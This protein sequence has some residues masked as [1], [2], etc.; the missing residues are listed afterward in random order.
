MRLI[1]GLRW[2]MGAGNEE[3]LN[4]AGFLKGIGDES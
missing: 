2:R 1:T 4:P 3:D